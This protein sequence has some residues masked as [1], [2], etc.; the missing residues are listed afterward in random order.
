VACLSE[1]PSF[2][3]RSPRGAT[4][5]GL[6]RSDV[7]HLGHVSL[8]PEVYL[9][10]GSWLLDLSVDAG[11]SGAIGA[12]GWQFHPGMA[13]IARVVALMRSCRSCLM[14]NMQAA[15]S[16]LAVGSAMAVSLRESLACRVGGPCRGLPRWRVVGLNIH[17]SVVADLDVSGCRRLRNDRCCRPIDDSLRLNGGLNTF[18]VIPHVRGVRLMSCY[19]AAAD[20]ALRIPRCCTA[21][22]A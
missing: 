10:I 2:G 5:A 20:A 3:R 16:C 9:P 7:G 17:D 11:S 18:S 15:R 1:G 13:P 14:P 21:S 12:G 4:A 19:A 8:L 6:D 22:R